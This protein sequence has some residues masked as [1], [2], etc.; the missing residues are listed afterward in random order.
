VADAKA[1]D[2]LERQGDLAEAREAYRQAVAI[3]EPL[4]AAD[5]SNADWQQGLAEDYA[6]L[7][8]TQVKLGDNAAAWRRCAKVTI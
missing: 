1:G 7:A 3:M 5:R 2:V 6:S 4:A 8:A